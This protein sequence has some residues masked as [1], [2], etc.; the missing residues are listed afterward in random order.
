M[1]QLLRKSHVV[2]DW[3]V[4]GRFLHPVGLQEALRMNRCLLDVHM[5]GLD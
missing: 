2:E 4:Q 5:V 1:E 3:P